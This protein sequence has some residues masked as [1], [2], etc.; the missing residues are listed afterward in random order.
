MDVA[1]HRLW[2]G[3]RQIPLR[4]KTWDVLRYLLGRPGLLVTKEALHRAIW[5]DAAVSDDALTKSIGELRRALGDTSRTPRLIETVHGRG[6]RFVAE[7]HD[8]SDEKEGP[9]AG[10]DLPQLTIA[11]RPAESSLPFVGRQAELHQLQECLRRAGQ[12]ERQLVF[13]TGE[14]GIGKTTLSEAFLRSPAVRVPDVL[15]LHGQCIHQHG[16]REPYMPVLEALERLLRSAAGP[17]LIPLFRRVAPCWYAQ[18]PWLLAENASRPFS[19]PSTSAPP[20]RMLR[21][22][23]TF[24][25]SV[26]PHSTV[27][28]ALEDL[29]W[30]DHAT[31]D[32]LSFLAERRDPS[33]LLI[34]GTYRPAEASAHDHPIREIKQ[35]LR[36]R[37]RCLEIPLDYL[38]TANVREYLHERFGDRVLELAPLIHRRTD[39]NPLFVVSV[40]EELVRRGQLRE[41]DGGWVVG[42][43]MDHLDL[44]IPDDL[45]EM[46]TAQFQRL[47]AD[48]RSVLEVASVAG[49]SF[50]P[51][52]VAQALGRDVEDVEAIAQCLVRS[53]LFLTFANREGGQGELYAFYHALHHQ[54][55]YE[56]VP[57]RRRRRW[58]QTIG[59][60]L[61]E[62]HGESL[63]EVAPE[64]SAH[65]ERSR[66]YLRAARYLG[67]CAA[68]AQQRLAP[69][70][71]I[72]C[73]E[74]GLGLLERVPMTPDR[75]RRELELRLLLGV[76]L[77]ITRGYCSPDVRNNYERARQLCRAGG[78]SA[79][80]FEI[81]HALWYAQMNQAY[82][83]E[84]ELS[85]GEM[86]RLAEREGGAA[87][88]LRAD[89]ARARTEFW[90]GNIRPAVHLYARFLEGSAQQPIAVRAETYG[91][92][93]VVPAQMQAGL[94]H[95][96]LGYPAQA[97]ILAERGVTYA[98]K[99]G[100]PLALAS[101]VTHSTILE[102]L[103]GNARGAADLAE[104]TAKVCADNDIA[105]FSPMSRFFGGAAR[106]EGSDV[107][108]ALSEMLTGRG[109]HRALV[110][111]H[112]CGIMLAFL[113]AA[114]GRV[115]R[116]DEGLRRVEEGIELAEATSEGVYAAELW[117]L[118][119]E[120]L[121]GK[122]AR[123]KGKT[124]AVRRG[125][126]APEQCFRRALEIARQQGARSLEL[127]AATSLARLSADGDARGEARELLRSLYA[128]F[129]E[130]S[131]TKDL[132]DAKALL[133]G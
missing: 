102:L 118:N 34:V 53:R 30:S 100:Q 9:S 73:A 29:H 33:R 111:P 52:T 74:Q 125:A 94:A 88:R 28:L 21:E 86:A 107:A 106:T 124:R 116:W 18:V 14:A 57:G 82:I 98:E 67:M 84:A 58:H 104:R 80:L 41:M 37:R 83:A 42:M 126:D 39:G 89:L 130:G 44:R 115:E 119:G 47:T 35:I 13:I 109:E 90:K 20:E 128:S 113:A 49:V 85:V 131:D 92:D 75:H 127:R 38:S 1:S 68:R 117:R 93:P 46:V 61:E 32:L 45:R 79:E 22:I 66:D 87:F 91:P 24:L 62:T 59:E 7:V 12:G 132:I 43:T 112:G 2:R 16:G 110:G 64:L 101:A 63:P 65:F 11:S 72:A 50:A 60:T 6:F 17:T 77:S 114:Y 55:I 27:V 133:D 121:H 56:Q 96:F 97:R 19:R 40:V 108:G 36:S 120:L 3:D 8:V 122:A 31:V 10:A 4:P 25:E 99:S 123:S 76:P 54:V 70:E 95:W 23:G 78:D 103:C 5:P 105:Y 48:A 129:T 81:L 15:V 71:A 51:G 69:R 26:S